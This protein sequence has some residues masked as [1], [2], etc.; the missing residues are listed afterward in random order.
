MSEHFSKHL[1]EATVNWFL[2]KKKKKQVFQLKKVL[3]ICLTNHY[4]ATWV[5]LN[6]NLLSSCSFSQDFRNLMFLL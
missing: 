4:C 1:L 2:K 5:Y 3:S 6:Y